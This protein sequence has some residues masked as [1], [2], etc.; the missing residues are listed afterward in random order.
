MSQ[1]YNG[2]QIFWLV[3][4]YSLTVIFNYYCVKFLPTLANMHLARHCACIS[5]LNDILFCGL[6]KHSLKKLCMRDLRLNNNFVHA[7][8]HLVMDKNTIQTS[9]I[10]AQTLK[11][12]NG[13]H[14]NS[15]MEIHC[16]DLIKT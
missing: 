1:S 11:Q 14:L 6:V 15:R 4:P 10:I 7:K 16:L 3:K 8:M 13:M 9:M 5:N 2:L 12:K